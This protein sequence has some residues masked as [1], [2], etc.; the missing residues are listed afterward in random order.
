[1]EIRDLINEQN[2]DFFALA[3]TW[4]NGYD[5]AKIS[6]M[7]PST[8]FFVHVPRLSKRGGGVGVFISREFKQIKTICTGDFTSFEHIHVNFKTYLDKI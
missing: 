7:T 5:K 2:L 1:M 8:H 4:L 3:A 6:E